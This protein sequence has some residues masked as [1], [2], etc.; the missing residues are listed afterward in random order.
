MTKFEISH[1]LGLASLR[2]NTLSADSHSFMRV[3]LYLRK[4]KENIKDKNNIKKHKQ[5]RLQIKDFTFK[6]TMSIAVVNSAF[7]VESAVIQ[8]IRILVH[9]RQ[10]ITFT[11][12]AEQC[13]C[14]YL[15][16]ALVSLMET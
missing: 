10:Y 16:S 11:H 14:Y 5:H 4:F 2:G 6:T 3:I 1:L 15:I 8:E 12:I 13:S 9:F 7:C